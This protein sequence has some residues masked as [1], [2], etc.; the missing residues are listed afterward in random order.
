[1]TVLAFLCTTRRAHSTTDNIEMFGPLVFFVVFLILAT[2][3]ASYIH[4]S[5][6]SIGKKRAIYT[7]I[8]LL[9][10]VVVALAVVY[11]MFFMRLSYC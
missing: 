3:C 4:K 6:F 1:M 8:V 2:W 10:S 11:V 7:V 9:S 5:S